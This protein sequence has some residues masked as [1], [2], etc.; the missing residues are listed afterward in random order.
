MICCS[1]GELF[2]IEIFSLKLPVCDGA[3]SSATVVLSLTYKVVGISNG[4]NNSL[5]SKT[6]SSI[7]KVADPVLVRVILVV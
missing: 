3:N 6:N 1:S 2:L 4:N 7:I 5:E